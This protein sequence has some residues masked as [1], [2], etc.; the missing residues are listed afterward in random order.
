MGCRLALKASGCALHGAS[1]G[2]RLQALAE[3]RETG[4][5]TH[6]CMKILH[7]F[8]H[9]HGGWAHTPHLCQ[10]VGDCVQLGRED[11]DK[12]GTLG[13]EVPRVVYMGQC[14]LAPVR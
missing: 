6:A 4:A 12:R 9:S 13:P 8:G 1:A 11:N 2:D 3:V 14:L 5:G 10:A 7:P